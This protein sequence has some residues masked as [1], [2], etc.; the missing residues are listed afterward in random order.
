[1]SPEWYT[2]GELLAV[3]DGQRNRMKAAAIEVGLALFG[4]AKE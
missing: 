1:V 4:P 3:A 2:F